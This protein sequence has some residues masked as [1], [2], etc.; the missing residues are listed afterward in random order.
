LNRGRA[1]TKDT[2]EYFLPIQSFDLDQSD[3]S[4][5]SRIKVDF[6]A[7]THIGKVRRINEDAF[8]IA[9]TGRYWRKILTNVEELFARDRYEENAY[10]LAVADG[11][12]SLPAG[13]AA[14]RTALTTVVNLM[15]SSVKW[16]LKLDHPE[17]RDQEIRE[18]ITRAVEYLSKTDQ[19]ISRKAR[20]EGFH[21]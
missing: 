12:G 8:L 3:E 14:S 2:P 19:E 10:A 20:R 16:A 13:E 4:F 11:I 15:L 18:A 5:S 21:R 9:Q 7:A 1:M 6:G 17:L